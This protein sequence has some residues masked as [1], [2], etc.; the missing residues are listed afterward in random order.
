M[1]GERVRGRGHSHPLPAGWRSVIRPRSLRRDGHR[2]Q[3]RIAGVC[4]GTATHVD[5]IVPAWKGGSDDDSNL[6]AACRPCHGRKTGKEAAEARAARPG[7]KRPAEPHPGM[8]R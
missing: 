3:L 1:S 8:I 5:H 6:Q 4:I 2:C 7:R